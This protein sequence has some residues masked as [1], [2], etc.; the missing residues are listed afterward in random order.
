MPENDSEQVDIASIYATAC[1]VQGYA[2]VAYA[3]D[4]HLNEWIDRLIQSIEVER[5]S[6][7]STESD[8]E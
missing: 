5:A 8:H 1:Y 7:S 6:V 3:G 4:D 2:S